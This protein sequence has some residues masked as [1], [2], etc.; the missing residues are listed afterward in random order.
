MRGM[1][2]SGGLG[3]WILIDSES[4]LSAVIFDSFSLYVV[5]GF[6]SVNRLV[7]TSFSR[8][9]CYVSTKLAG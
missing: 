1:R 2:R 4:S 7:E 6:G 3:D 8:L 5:Y 9:A